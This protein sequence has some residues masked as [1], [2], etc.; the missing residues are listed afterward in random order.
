MIFDTDKYGNFQLKAIM[1]GFNFHGAIYVIPA[2]LKTEVSKRENSTENDVIWD[3][4]QLDLEI[5]IQMKY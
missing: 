3:Y 4:M 2:V 5:V 1:Y